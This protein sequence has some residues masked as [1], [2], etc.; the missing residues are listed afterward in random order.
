MNK[1]QQGFITMSNKTP[2]YTIKAVKAYNAK[3]IRHE[4][5]ALPNSKRGQALQKA[6]LDQNFVLNFWTWLEKEYSTNN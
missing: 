1:Q 3:T 4:F 5:K 2:S 6:K